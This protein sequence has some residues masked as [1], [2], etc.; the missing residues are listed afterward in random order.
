MCRRWILILVLVLV[1][2]PSLILV[3]AATPQARAGWKTYI[4]PS[5]HL[6]VDY[7]PDWTVRAEDFSAVFSSP[8]G[9]TIRLEPSTP[10]SSDEIIQPNTRCSTVINPHGISVHS[11]RSTIGAAIDAYLDLKSAGGPGGATISTST[12]AALDIFTALVDSARVVP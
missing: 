12:R 2:A 6:A 8:H 7:P 5:L 10:A 3:T 9:A 4:Y 1:P 11:C